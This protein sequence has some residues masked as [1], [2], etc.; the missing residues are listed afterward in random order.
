[1][2]NISNYISTNRFKNSL[3]SFSLIFCKYAL[4]GKLVLNSVNKL[5]YFHDRNFY[6]AKLIA[7]YAKTGHTDK[8]STMQT[9]KNVI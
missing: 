1:M 3:K 7:C 6:S 5:Q 8:K 4:A 9:K 2:S